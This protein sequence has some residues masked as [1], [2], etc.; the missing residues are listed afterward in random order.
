MTR[1]LGLSIMDSDDYDDPEAI[2]KSM[3]TGF[4]ANMA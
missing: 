3:I 4:F 1:K 2:L